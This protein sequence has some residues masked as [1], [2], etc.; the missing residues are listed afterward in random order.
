M[1]GFA[2]AMRDTQHTRGMPY[3]DRRA[4]RSKR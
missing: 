2:I 4:K 1:P 3:A